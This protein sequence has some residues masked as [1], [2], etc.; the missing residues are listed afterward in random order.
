MAKKC[1]SYLFE[2]NKIIGF[3]TTQGVRV[4]Q[5][6]HDDGQ[7]KMYPLPSG[8]VL[9]DNVESEEYENVEPSPLT[10]QQMQGRHYENIIQ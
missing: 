3:R 10:D 5:R 1:S 6:G 9:Y 8:S 7:L 4:K 2:L